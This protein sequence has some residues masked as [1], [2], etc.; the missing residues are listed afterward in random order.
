MTSRGNAWADNVAAEYQ[1]LPDG[2]ALVVEI[3]R[4]IDRVDDLQ[5]LIDDARDSGGL[6]IQTSQGQRLHPAI[7]EQRSVITV[8]QRALASLGLQGPE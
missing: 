1:L 6:M 3:A 7:G 4:L 8:L 2:E 5:A